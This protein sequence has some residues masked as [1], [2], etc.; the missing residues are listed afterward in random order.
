M[1]KNFYKVKE[2]RQAVANPANLRWQYA[3]ESLLENNKSTDDDAYDRIFLQK[4]VCLWRIYSIQ[5]HIVSAR[6][7]GK[8]RN[9]SVS[10]K[11]KKLKN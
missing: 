5:K 1:N 9:T 2:P 7:R 6:F 11:T 4:A 3:I 8:F 10:K